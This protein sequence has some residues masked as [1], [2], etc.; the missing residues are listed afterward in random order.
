[1]YDLTYFLVYYYYRIYVLTIT[2]LYYTVILKVS[3]LLLLQL[4]ALRITYTVPFTTT[5]KVFA[6]QVPTVCTSHARQRFWRTHFDA[7]M[8]AC[9]PAHA[10]ISISTW[11]PR[12][13]YS[14]KYAIRPS[15]S[16]QKKAKPRT[17]HSQKKAQ[18][19]TSTDQTNI[20]S[21]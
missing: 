17:H 7:R 3:L 2:L 6:A 16:H 4:H 1:M 14:I 15:Q 13:A 20:P 18:F 12:I 9:I 8:H 5:Y 10:P 11:S 19:N 21:E